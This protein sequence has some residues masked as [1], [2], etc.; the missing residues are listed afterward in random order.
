[1]SSSRF[2][3]LTDT[4]NRAG[5]ISFRIR[6]TPGCRVSQMGLGSRSR[7]YSEGTW[8]SNWIMPAKNTPQARAKTGSANQGAATVAAKISDRLR[9]TGVKAGTAKRP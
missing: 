7:R 4:P 6:R 1:M 5:T 9:K 2:I 8:N 3:W